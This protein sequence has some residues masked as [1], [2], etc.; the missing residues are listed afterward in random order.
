MRGLSG[1]RGLPPGLV[2]G[3]F[4]PA[5][6]PVAE[7]SPFEGVFT[8]VEEIA[9]RIVAVARNARMTSGQTAEQEVRTLL[10][11][12]AASREAVSYLEQAQIGVSRL[13]GL[14]QQLTS[15][16]T[17]R[18]QRLAAQASTLASELQRAIA[19]IQE[20]KAWKPRSQE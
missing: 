8:A 16:A 2:T 18:E 7:D 6:S 5:A 15:Q 19:T 14:A 1:P 13:R 20:A 11:I 4:N 12:E 3:T 10:E 9:T 17:Q